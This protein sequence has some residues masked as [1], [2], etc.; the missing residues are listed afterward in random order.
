MYM[1]KTPRHQFVARDKQNYSYH[2]RHISSYRGTI[3]LQR[4]RIRAVIFLRAIIINDASLNGLI[5]D[6]DLGSGELASTNTTL[7]EQ[8]QLS[9]GAAARLG[10]AEVCIY[11]AEEADTAPEET[12]VVAPVPGAGIEHVRC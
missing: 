7:E 4:T 3:F 9:E 10:N 11:N 12:G 1:Q 5:K 6:I 2:I 8:I